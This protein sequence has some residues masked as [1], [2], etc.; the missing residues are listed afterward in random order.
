MIVE[1]GALLN[2]ARNHFAG[3]GAYHKSPKLSNPHIQIS[4][5]PHIRIMWTALFDENMSKIMYK[6]LT[7]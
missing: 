4:P 2:K 3:R 6:N 7:I 5:N 1:Y